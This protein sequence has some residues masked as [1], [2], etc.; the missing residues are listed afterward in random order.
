MTVPLLEVAAISR[1]FRD[2]PS[3]RRRYLMCPPRYFDVSYSIN[4]WMDRSVPVDRARAT[5]QWEHLVETYERLGHD[6][7]IIEPVPEGP[8]MVFSANSAVVD[9]GRVLTA[10]FR[11]PERT[12]EQRPYRQW[13]VER[14]FSEVRAARA[15]CEG[16][17]DVTF[18]GPVALAGWGFRT[19]R[20]AHH[21][22]QEFFGRP[23]VSLRLCDPRFYHLDMAL[24]VLDERTVAYFPPAFSAGS[25]CV[26]ERLFPDAIRVQKAD[27]F[28]LGLNAVCDGEHVVLA[29]AAEGMADLVRSRGLEPVPVDMSEF[30]KAGGSVKCCTLEL[31]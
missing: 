19:S 8:D 11:H 14:E 22:L 1:G 6:V 4:P 13:F 9:G 10:R 26:L 17:G 27:A 12:P 16:E 20:G 28:A 21:E 18:V 24:C 5:D 15:I 25:R 7:E 29:A 30:A 2:R 31:R 3:R 23:V